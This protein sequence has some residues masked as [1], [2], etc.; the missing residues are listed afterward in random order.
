MRCISQKNL[1]LPG[2]QKAIL[3]VENVITT[4]S[5]SGMAAREVKQI[6]PFTCS[7]TLEIW[8]SGKYH[9]QSIGRRVDGEKSKGAAEAS[10]YKPVAGDF[11]RTPGAETF[12]DLDS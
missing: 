5:Y 12:A 6:K 11:S 8:R 1:A 3:S 7:A 9:L 10:L 2:H 4:I